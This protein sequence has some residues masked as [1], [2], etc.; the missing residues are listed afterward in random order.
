MRSPAVT[1]NEYPKAGMVELICDS[2]YLRQEVDLSPELKTSLGN[3][4]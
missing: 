3:V 1:E 4:M 2:S